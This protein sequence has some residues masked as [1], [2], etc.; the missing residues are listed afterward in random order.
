[1]SEESFSILG[2]R[3]CLDGGAMFGNVPKTLWSQ[4]IDVNEYNQ[5]QLATRALFV[6]KNNKNIL[7]EV[8][9]G[10]GISTKFRN[11]YGILEDSHILLDSLKSIGI[12]HNDI[13]IIVLSHLHFD[14]AGGLLS[15]FREPYKPE[16][17][18]PK[19]TIIVSKLAWERA[20]YPHLRDKASFIPELIDLLKNSNRLHLVDEYQSS[21][22]GNGIRFHYSHGHTPG[23]LMS[24]I[25]IKE[26]K[27]LF[28]SDLI[29]ARPWIK[30]AI[31]MG[32]DRY[33]E[34]LINEKN[35][36][37]RYLLD[38]KI[39]LFFTHDKEVESCLIKE[40]SE[41]N[42]VEDESSIIWA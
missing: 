4:W 41:G 11:R 37:I 13:D 38:N 15:V 40:S 42:Y 14:H 22:L 18:F 12:S 34:L 28:V 17:L 33:P 1:M 27:Y 20:C 6:K 23:L 3:Q 36:L 32:Y 7:F 9:I 26:Q 39:R 10:T 31:T 5:V 2:N 29:P 24:E 35:N 25:K 16:L 30:L 19:A 8:G 21:L